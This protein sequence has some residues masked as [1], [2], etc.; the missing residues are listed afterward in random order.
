MLVVKDDSEKVRLY[1]IMRRRATALLAVFAAIFVVTAIVGHQRPDLAPF[2]VGLVRATAEAAMVGGIADWFA[3]TAL[4]RHPLG[5]P[6]P[7]TAIVAQRKD[8]I[9]RSLGNFVGNNFLAREVIAR[10]LSGMRLGERTAQWLSEPDHQSRVA[11]AIAGGVARAAESIPS[12][13]LRVTVHE[14]LVEQLRKAQIAPLLG[15]LLALATTDDR[16]QEMLDRLVRLV[17][18]IVR[19]NKELI[20]VRISEESPWWVPGAVDDKLFQKIVAGI[21]RT[22]EQVASDEQHPLREQFDHA[23][24]GFVEKL[25][26][27]PETIARAESM[28]EKL[29]EHPAVAELSDALLGAAQT[30]LAKY[31][32]PEAP[33]S[34]PLERAIG[35]IADRALGNPAFLQDVDQAVERLVL[36][37]VDQYRPE[38]A[39]LIAKTVEGWD[40]TDASRK[41]E[42]QIGRDLQFIR[43]NGTLVGGLVGLILYVISTLVR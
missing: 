29:L 37:V 10:Q 39:E 2:W 9:G 43:I 15:D 11:R 31:S 23:L 28:K 19:D 8:R 42:V 33:S 1:A 27:S 5:I 26:N 40:A 3:V 38:V 24:R 6:I 22:L 32:G 16:H 13:E 7:H 34:E 36:G 4:F 21:E 20:R 18:R 14:T 17:S 12:A 41:I 35:A 30:S 25:H